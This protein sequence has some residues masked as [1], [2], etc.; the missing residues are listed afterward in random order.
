LDR[1]T[2]R[3]SGTYCSPSSRKAIVCGSTCRN[4]NADAAIVFEPHESSSR[5]RSASPFGRSTRRAKIGRPTVQYEGVHFAAITISAMA[6]M[7]T[8]A[9]PAI[10]IGMRK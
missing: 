5:E 2:P 8:T 4:T 7:S 9:I 6:T 3:M 1:I 10:I